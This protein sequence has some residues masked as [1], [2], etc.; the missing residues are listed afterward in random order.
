MGR[1]WERSV[2]VVGAT[3]TAL[4]VAMT[5]YAARQP[6]ALASSGSGSPAQS[7][8]ASPSSSP[9]PSVSP[10]PSPSLPSSPSPSPSPSP[11][12]PPTAVAFGG[13]AAVGALF[14]V[15]KGKLSHLCTAAV[16]QSP[17]GDLAITAAHCL[18]GKRLGPAGNV[19]FAPGYHDGK[20]PHGRWA[21]ISEIVDSRWRKDRDP[22]DDVAFFV[23]GRHGRRIEKYTGAE[24]VKTSIKL[25]QLVQVIGYPSA[26]NLPVKCTAPARRLPRA[27]YLQMVFD[28]GGFTG[29]TSGGPFLMDVNRSTGAGDVIGVIGGYEEGGDLPSVSYSPIFLQNVAALYK[30]AIS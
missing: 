24:T 28:C 23:V 13:T 17:H 10:S 8:A 27:G 14:I 4:G 6:A 19:I 21:V 16:V 15:N 20:F 9:S 22:N 26:T 30:Q 25:P 12:Q 11:S 18:L 29:G 2:A 1:R 7:A 3:V 5:F